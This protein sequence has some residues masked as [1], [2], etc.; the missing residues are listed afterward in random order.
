[1]R[2]RLDMRQTARGRGRGAR[3]QLWRQA[4]QGLES[5]PSIASCGVNRT[6]AAVLSENRPGEKAN[7]PID[8]SNKLTRRCE[9]ESR[10]PK[11]IRFCG[12]DEQKAIARPRRR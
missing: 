9:T 3:E 7:P 12:K 4:S 10:E 6:A 2:L 1:M 5:V 11:Q 8:R